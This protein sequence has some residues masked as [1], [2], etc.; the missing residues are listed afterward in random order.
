MRKLTQN[1]SLA[2]LVIIL[3][4]GCSRKKDKFLNKGFHSTTTKYNYLFNGNN[5][6]NQG[7]NEINVSVLDNFWDVLP[8]EKSSLKQD[9][10]FEKKEN[11]NS[12]LFAQSEEKAVLV[13]QKHAM[14]IGGKEKNPQMDQAYF[15]LGESRY[16]DQRFIPAL[17]AFNYI[18]FKYPTSE[19]VNKAKIW[20]E[21]INIKL[22]YNELAVDNLN[23]IKNKGRLSKDD[24]T[25]LNVVLSQAYL[26]LKKIDSA[27]HYLKIASENTT[28]LKYKARYFFILGQLYSNLDKKDSSSI[29]FDRIIKL[30]RKI[31]RDY[32]VYSFIEKSKNYENQNEAILELS[33][34]EKD[35][36]NKEYL[37][38]IFHQIAN[39]KLEI[40]ADSLAINY[41]NKSL[42]SPAKD[43]LLN[44]KNHNILADYYFHNKQY[45]SSAAHYDSTLL[46]IRND[47]RLYRKITKKRSSL[48]DVI[49]YEL[50][51][52][53]N[54]SIL[55]L[56]NMSEDE[57][58]LFFNSYLQ[59]IKDKLKFEE[60]I[61]DNKNNI[62]LASK[63]NS[64]SSKDALFYFYNPTA[65][66]YGK[67]EFKKLWGQIKRTDNWRN[68]QKK[69]TSKFLNTKKSNILQKKQPRDLESY[70]KTIPSSL[71]VI[72]SISI[73]L[74]Y[75]YFQLASIYSSKFL[76]YDLSNN[77]IAKINFEIKNDKIILPAKYL[78]YKNCLVLG[79]IKKADSIKLD[80]IKNYPDSKYAEILNNPD[81]LASSELDN[82][83]EIYS[84]LFKDFQNQKY[85]QLIVELDELIATYE[86][87]PLVPKMQLLKA[88]AV[89]RIQGFES[90]KT[91][92]E[93]IS[94]NYSNSVEGKEAKILLDQVIPLLKNSKFEQ[95]DEGE[96]FK[97][98][99]S[100]PK[101]NKKETE[102][103]KVQLN[104][105]VKDLKN[106]EL[107]SSTDIYDNSI[108]FV[109][110]HGLK[111]FDGAMGLNII[112]EKNK[113]II[114][115]SS[116]VISSKNYQILQIHK[117]LSLYLKNNL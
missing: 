101:E 21:K 45:L 53:K 94:T 35:I 17:E 3:L 72:D 104:L 13:I 83:T 117:N 41:Y 4:A 52:K 36:E 15:L 81:S 12:N 57:R 28:D 56:V 107:S 89:A 113:N 54:D 20:R 9:T 59:K 49:Y 24:K 115:D 95:M 87:D 33:E 40:N 76:D 26:N 71:T 30:H 32:Y 67:N 80:I 2:L 18:L 65:V 99:Y 44:V 27:L 93:F 7:K 10:K 25:N 69:A 1:I 110:L 50:S 68:G 62:S 6:L 60:D 37:S 108:T 34:L 22:N 38:V 55:R 96:N 79:L 31:P 112:L 77:K 42:R 5:L 58:V 11:E 102:L 14:N 106:I 105:A 23:N 86:T 114:N 73:Q 90:Y 48:D 88:S 66:A 63:N 43:Y 103:F 98:I 29:F 109:V 91:I 16:F 82:L 47:K 75:A 8:T 61:I 116:F 46:N 39:L 78:N 100:F 64:I 111:S 19:L 85:T 51:V 70:L 92:L 84:G 97:L 74:D